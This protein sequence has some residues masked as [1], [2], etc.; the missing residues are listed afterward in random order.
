MTHNKPWE[1]D[2]WKSAKH[3]PALRNL[4]DT[5]ANR[6]W[7]EAFN[8]LGPQREITRALDLEQVS[9]LGVLTASEAFSRSAWSSLYGL[10]GSIGLIEKH[11]KASLEMDKFLS[12]Y[13]LRSMFS[14]AAS[15]FLAH[16]DELFSVMK[17]FVEAWP[18]LEITRRSAEGM[19]GLISLGKAAHQFSSSPVLNEFLGKWDSELASKA[20]LTDWVA[21][22]Q[23]YFECGFDERLTAFPGKAFSS[24]LSNTGL[25]TELTLPLD[26][27]LPVAQPHW[28]AEVVQPATSRNPVS[29]RPVSGNHRLRIAYFLIS[30]LETQLRSFVAKAME[31][32]FGSHWIK[33]RVPGETRKR[34]EE[35]RFAAKKAGETEARLLWYADFPDYEGIII[36][37]DNWRGLFEAIFQDLMEVQV[38]FRR[39]YPIRNST[40][41]ARPI[42]KADLVMLAVE[43]RRIL[44]AIGRAEQKS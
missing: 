25:L 24:V 18:G 27:S 3:H 5:F 20:I 37:S 44:S 36:R 32:S 8:A 23:F 39:V 33:Q 35:R 42:S 29:S 43:V 41:H 17:K 2:D 40:M 12:Q 30:N 19:I 4:S 22:R 9:G 26:V 38:S 10:S 31:K 14:L 6:V 1:T 28:S 34:W 11:L 7:N 13:E 21:R 16:K 15:S